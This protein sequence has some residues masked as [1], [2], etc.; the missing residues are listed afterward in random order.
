[1]VRGMG[2]GKSSPPPDIPPPVTTT[3]IEAGQ[4]A[5]LNRRRRRGRYDSTDTLLTTRGPQN[6]D[7]QG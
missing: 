6:L 7:P 2:K 1:M 4:R 5:V 3:G